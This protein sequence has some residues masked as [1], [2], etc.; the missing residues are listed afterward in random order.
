MKQKENSIPQIVNHNYLLQN[1]QQTILIKIAQHT[2][3][4]IHTEEAHYIDFQFIII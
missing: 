1:E 3:I 4:Y 2:Y